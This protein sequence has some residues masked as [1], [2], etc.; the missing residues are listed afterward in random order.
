MKQILGIF[1][2]L[3]LFVGCSSGSNYTNESSAR[4]SYARIFLTPERNQN[5]VGTMLKAP[6]N[7]QNTQEEGMKIQSQVIFAGFDY[8][9]LYA[10][11]GDVLVVFYKYGRQGNRA[12]IKYT[13][14]V[15]FREGRM[16]LDNHIT[17]DRIDY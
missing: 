2:V 1:V 5:V 7:L 8:C 15:N 3:F 14:W 4:S 17:I 10:K 9:R 11:H 16:R 6:I 12:M 13:D